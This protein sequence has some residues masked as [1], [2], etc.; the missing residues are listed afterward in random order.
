MS[1]VVSGIPLEVVGTASCSSPP[2]PVFP[3]M[4]DSS[5]GVV[6]SDRS[7]CVALGVFVARL[8]SVVG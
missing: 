5:D 8:G 3:L 7:G 6:C 2:S 1:D 4:L